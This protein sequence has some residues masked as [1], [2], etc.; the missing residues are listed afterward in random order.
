LMVEP[1]EA[2]VA[3]ALMTPLGR[4]FCSPRGAEKEHAGQSD[5]CCPRFLGIESG[6]CRLQGARDRH[7]EYSGIFTTSLLASCEESEGSGAMDQPTIPT[8][9]T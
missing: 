7:Q 9:L 6:L 5:P 2:P 3:K 1:S 8:A 4:A